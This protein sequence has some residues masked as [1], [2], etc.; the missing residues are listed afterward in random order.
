MTQRERLLA[1][2]VAVLVLLVIGTFAFNQ[3]Q[4]TVDL[5]DA[6]IRNLKSRVETEEFTIDIKGLRA[7][8]AYNDYLSRSLP[9]ISAVA[10]SRYSDW[11]RQVVE[12]VGL[13]NSK[14]DY[15]AARNRGELYKQLQFDIVGK[16]NLDQVT[17]F[18]FAFYQQR[19]LH[20]IDRITL[21]PTGKTLEVLNISIRIEAVSMTAKK[22]KIDL[23]PM[24]E[25]W[26]AMSS[27]RL[28]LEKLADYSR[29][30]AGRNL[31]APGN[32][33]PRFVTDDSAQEMTLGR[34]GSV[35]IRADAGD[36]DQDLIFRVIS[37]NYPDADEIPKETE[38]GRFSFTPEKI[39]DFNM[40]VEVQDSGPGPNNK[41]TKEFAFTVKEP[42]PEPEREDPPPDFD[43][44]RSMYITAVIERNGKPQLWLHLRTT[45]ETIQLRTGDEFSVADATG[46][47]REISYETGRVQFELGGQ[48]WQA[49]RGGN[50]ADVE[51]VGEAEKATN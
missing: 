12:D 25:E 8:K 30:I 51:P 34:R 48:V 47:V 45:N 4:E 41:A 15:V 13:E 16:G 46:T 9:G 22:D 23:K 5:K 2:A 17:E 32:Q 33:I 36:R 3:F 43:V 26:R 18:L 31:F 10:S 37:T 7:R 42:E 1:G 19:H 28:R 39:G 24:E 20:R 21:Q 38:S 50:L 6:E 14:V 27:D 44:A 35:R 40:V 29:F 11:L 49:R